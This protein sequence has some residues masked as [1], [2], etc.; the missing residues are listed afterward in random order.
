MLVWRNDIRDANEIKSK[1]GKRKLYNYGEC[2]LSHL[3]LMKSIDTG[4][5]L[6][7]GAGNFPQQ[8][9]SGSEFW[10]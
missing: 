5:G 6:W 9:N 10:S 7:L 1:L 4:S 8:A 3:C 2:L